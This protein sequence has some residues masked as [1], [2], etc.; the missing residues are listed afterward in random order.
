MRTRDLVSE[1][2]RNSSAGQAKVL[3]SQISSHL[4]RKI[5]SIQANWPTADVKAKYR[6]SKSIK[7]NP[8]YLKQILDTDEIWLFQRSNAEI[9]IN[10]LDSNSKSGIFGRGGKQCRGVRGNEKLLIENPETTVRRF[11]VWGNWTADDQVTKHLG[12]YNKDAS[13]WDPELD[14]VALEV[15]AISEGRG[16]F[17]REDRIDFVKEYIHPIG[18]LKK[19]GRQT[20]YARVELVRAPL[21]R[22]KRISIFHGYPI[23]KV[24][25]LDF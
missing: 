10:C 11:Q 25:Y 6:L 8:D 1:F 15:A 5:E 22:K 16:R 18:K 19:S 17:L 7:G 24:E 12:K 9:A 23:S 20:N 14:R 2:R 4:T 3:A 21:S 13:V